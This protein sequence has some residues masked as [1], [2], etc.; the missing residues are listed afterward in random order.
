MK[1]KFTATEKIREYILSLLEVEKIQ[2]GDR[3][4]PAREIASKK[5]VSF[6]KAQH[7]I[8]GLCSDGILETVPRQG[9]FIKPEWNKRML[10]NSISINCLNTE[11]RDEIEKLIRS[12]IPEIRINKRNLRGDI[13]IDVTLRM[14]SNHDDCMDLSG[15]FDE[16]YPDKNIFYMEPLKHFI[17]EK[18][19]YAM[20][21][22]FSPRL[23]SYNMDMLKSAD[24]K[25]P[26]KN[27]NWNDFISIIK[28][29][30]KKYRPENIY[31]YMPNSGAN[32]TMAYVFR[33]GGNFINEK[34][35]LVINSEKTR[36]GLML[37]KSLLNELDYRNYGKPG[38]FEEGNLA[39]SFSPRQGL[40][41]KSSKFKFKWGVAPL[42]HI[43]G[44]ANITTQTTEGLWIHKSCVDLKLAR[45][46][47]KLVLS[48]KFQNCI[49]KNKYGIPIRKDIAEKSML[50]NKDP[51]DKL[52]FDE[53]PNM[54]AAYSVNN[55]E[56]LQWLRDGINNLLHKPD[57]DFDKALDELY[58]FFKNY[59]EI[60]EYQKNLWK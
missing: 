47:L 32:M 60:K 54:S 48:D 13:G 43:D 58:I 6:I 23:M 11:A 50:K 51:R 8:D 57:A 5:G 31:S 45:K 59:M 14:Q 41:S 22:L 2:S 16:L 3:L 21:I 15:L 9:T 39:F 7:A 52:F 55:P 38:V 36:K 35:E 37:Y 53:I 34:G 46:V 42:P 28:K 26:D 49:A 24:C 30:K 27:W 56:I 20:P 44:G 12:E 25:A 33:A 19:L 18:K 1:K 17:K 40:V 29:L 4:P 10:R